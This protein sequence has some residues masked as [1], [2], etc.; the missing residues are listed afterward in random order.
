LKEAFPELGKTQEKV[1]K[2]H[3]IAK[4][5]SPLEK[6]SYSKRKRDASRGMKLTR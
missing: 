5:A 3:Q 4:K 2:E 1:A 6:V